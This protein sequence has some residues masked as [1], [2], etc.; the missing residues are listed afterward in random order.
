MNPRPFYLNA[1]FSAVCG[2]AML[3]APQA[4][5]AAI[6]LPWPLALSVIGAGLVLFALQL[7]WVGRTGRRGWALLS[8][9]EDFAWVAA[10]PVVL[11]WLWPQFTALGVTALVLVAVLVELLGTWQWRVLRQARA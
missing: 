7:V 10:T 9:L 11:V 5:A 2:L 1:L 6:G 8:T 3:L 4:L